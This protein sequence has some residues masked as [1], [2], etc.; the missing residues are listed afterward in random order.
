MLRVGL[1]GG[2]ATGK[3]TVGRMFVDLGCH[4]LDSDLIT[5]ELFEPGQ[6]VRDAVAA[7]FGAAVLAANGSIDRRVLGEI[8]FNDPQ[9]RQQLNSL[10]HPAI[11]ERQQEWLSAVERENPHAVGI[12]SAALMIEVGTYRSYDRLIVVSCSPAEQLRRLRKRDALSEEQA[13]ARIASQ[14]PLSE[15]VRYADYVIDTSGELPATRSQVERINTILRE[16][17]SNTSDSSRS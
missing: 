2:I 10:V 4:L 7:A 15:K 17:A 12:V 13:E 14:M 9:L 6:A 5:R 16:Q 8:V 1:T 11:I 3:T